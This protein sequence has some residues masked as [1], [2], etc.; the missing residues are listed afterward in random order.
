M[1]NSFVA[2][3][4]RIQGSGVDIAF[5]GALHG[6]ATVATDGSYRRQTVDG[7]AIQ[8]HFPYDVHGLA[9]SATAEI[10]CLLNR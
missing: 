9:T 10:L 6:L 2:G 5:S 8:L 1:G 7:T 4:V 3:T